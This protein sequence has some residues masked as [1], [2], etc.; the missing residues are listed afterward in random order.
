LWGL[1]FWVAFIVPASIVGALLKGLSVFD[2][3]WL[4]L[5][6]IGIYALIGLGAMLWDRYGDSP[7]KGEFP[8]VEHG[9]KRWKQ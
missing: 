4:G 5:T 8:E 1:A 2:G 6:Y 9:I 3:V 7:G